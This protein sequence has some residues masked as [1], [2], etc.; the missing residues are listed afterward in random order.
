M[1][2]ESKFNIGDKIYSID[3]KMMNAVEFEVGKIHCSATAENGYTVYYS[4]KDS[5]SSFYEPWC[6]A[7]K[8]E[9]VAHFSDITTL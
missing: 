1:T 9:L 5:Y 2:F 8:E 7:S 6:F 3:A 4:P